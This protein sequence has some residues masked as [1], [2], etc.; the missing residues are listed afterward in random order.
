MAPDVLEG[1]PLTLGPAD[2]DGDAAGAWLG[3][4]ARV[5][6][7]AV[8]PVPLPAPYIY[9]VE[10][11][12]TPGSS[13]TPPTVAV[14]PWSSVIAT[15]TGTIPLTSGASRANA[16]SLRSNG[17]RVDGVRFDGA[18]FDGAGPG[19]AGR[20]PNRRAVAIQGD[21]PQ[22]QRPPKGEPVELPP[23]R[24]AATRPGTPDRAGPP[25]Q[26]GP[27]PDHE[28]IALSLDEP[29][30]FAVLYERYSAVLYRYA[31]RRLGEESAE[32]VVASAFLAAFQARHRYDRARPEARPWL[33]GILTKEIARRRRGEAARYRA[34]ARS[35]VDGPV[36]GLA[37]KVVADVGAQAA[38]G[39]LADALARLSAGDRNTLLIIAWGGLS[40]EET[41]LALEIPVGTVRS[42]LNRAR[43]KMRDAL[44]GKDPT[45]VTTAIAA[46]RDPAAGPAPAARRSVPVLPA[47]R[48]TTSLPTQEPR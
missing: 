25:D 11:C 16:V 9:T 30:Q 26:A 3:V 42:R 34:L 43:R 18:R 37:E 41:A 44:G 31:Y 29:E 28:V 23:S 4:T 6:S 46:D 1:V 36:D 40:Y 39:A 24:L 32:D 22:P 27:L 10:L 13:F 5:G 15:V 14:C 17:V 35:A 20:E 33:F 2:A 8:L 47:P 45:G 38:R 7:I 21:P 48:P 12:T 19:R